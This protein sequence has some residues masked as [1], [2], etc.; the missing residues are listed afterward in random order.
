[1]TLSGIVVNEPEKEEAARIASTVA[2]IGK[3]DNQ[4]R[5]MAPGRKFSTS[6]I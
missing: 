2:G 4:L 3:V 1:M 6:G 5:V